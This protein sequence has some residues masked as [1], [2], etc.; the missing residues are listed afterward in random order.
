MCQLSSCPIFK[1]T[2]TPNVSITRSHELFL[3]QSHTWSTKHGL[4]H[5]Y[6]SKSSCVVLTINHPSLLLCYSNITPRLE[7]WHPPSISS[8]TQTWHHYSIPL[9][10]PIKLNKESFVTLVL[11]CTCSCSLPC[12]CHLPVMTRHQHSRSKV[13]FVGGWSPRSCDCPACKNTIRK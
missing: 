10:S 13:S 9:S 11:A 6:A 1:I 7:H 8:F 12:H 5:G 4:P 2:H 3:H